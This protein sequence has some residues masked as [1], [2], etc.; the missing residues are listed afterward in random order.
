MYEVLL[1]VTLEARHRPTDNT[2]HFKAGELLPPPTR[3]TIARFAGDDGFY[4]LYLDSDGEE[5]TDTW[6]QS[7]EDAID[8]AKFEFSVEPDEWSVP[9]SD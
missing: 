3:L 5:Q 7:I 2:R 4:P 9:T 1:A 8:Q 6:H